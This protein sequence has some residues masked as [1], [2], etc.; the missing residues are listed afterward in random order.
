MSD[1]VPRTI[2]KTDAKT[3]S[4]VV[5]GS[6]TK[7]QLF[8]STLLVGNEIQSM[9]FKAKNMMSR[10]SLSGVVKSGFAVVWHMLK[11]V[12]DN[13]SGICPLNKYIYS[14][15]IYLLI[16]K[17]P[18]LDYSFLYQYSNELLDF[19]RLFYLRLLKRGKFEQKKNW[20][21]PLWSEVY[22]RASRW[23]DHVCTHSLS[24]VVGGITPLVF[25]EFE[26]TFG[27]SI[28]DTTHVVFQF[29]LWKLHN[30]FG[31]CYFWGLILTLCCRLPKVAPCL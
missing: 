29:F 10:N 19:K 20:L 28:L 11:W 7:D 17:Q 12:S 27:N 9:V 13:I 24:W 25:E 6:N 4:I 5:E 31:Q 1:N 30:F 23:K 26:P 3:W 2:F 14:L 15:F 21:V 16:P 8:L 22:D 18:P